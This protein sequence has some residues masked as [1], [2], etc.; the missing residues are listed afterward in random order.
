MG[1]SQAEIDAH[2]G[3]EAEKDRLRERARAYMASKDLEMN[4]AGFCTLGRDEIAR[5]STVGVLL[6][7]TE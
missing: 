1:Y 3:S 7:A 4:Q 6:R 5:N 2:V